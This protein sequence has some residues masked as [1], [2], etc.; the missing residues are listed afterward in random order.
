MKVGRFRGTVFR[1]EVNKLLS[2]FGREGFGKWWQYTRLSRS[3]TGR[4]EIVGPYQDCE[5]ESGIVPA[6][7][8]SGSSTADSRQRYGK[9]MPLIRKA[10]ERGMRSRGKLCIDSGATIKESLFLDSLVDLGRSGVYRISV[11]HLDHGRNAR[12]TSNSISAAIAP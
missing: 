5:M 8:R 4:I 2:V 12:V 3:H 11:R 1:P 10:R 6:T 9:T 7:T